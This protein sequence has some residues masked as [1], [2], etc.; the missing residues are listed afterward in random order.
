MR[1]VE[2]KSECKIWV[3]EEQQRTS[4]GDIRHDECVSRDRTTEIENIRY[5]DVNLTSIF[6]AL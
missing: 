3:A 2:I 4:N 5:L 6:T 1:L